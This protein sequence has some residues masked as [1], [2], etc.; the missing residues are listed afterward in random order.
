MKVEVP[1]DGPHDRTNC[2]ACMLGFCVQGFQSHVLQSAKSSPSTMTQ[3]NGCNSVQ[4]WAGLSHPKGN[5]GES[6]SRSP[7][8]LINI[9]TPLGGL[10]DTNG[11]ERGFQGS[12]FQSHKTEPSKPACSY[13]NNFQYQSGVDLGLDGST[14]AGS[15]FGFWHFAG[16]FCLILSFILRLIL[17]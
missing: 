17:K 12:Y 10:S 6:S 9:V 7:G 14:G 3:T 16:L 2:E 13:T 4:K 15:T 11:Y 8:R 5:H 1:L